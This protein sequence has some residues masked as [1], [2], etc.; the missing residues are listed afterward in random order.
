M[1]T[2]FVGLLAPKE[3]VSENLNKHLRNPVTIFFVK[4]DVGVP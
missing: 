1:S 2:A 3:A 4:F